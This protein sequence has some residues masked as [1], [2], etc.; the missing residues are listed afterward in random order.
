MLKINI[1]PET[2]GDTFWSNMYEAYERMSPSMREYLETLTA[3]HDANFFHKEAANL[4][5]KISTTKVRGNP[6]NVG[7][8]LQAHHPIIRTNRKL[9]Q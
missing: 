7:D 3:T 5:I 8:D 6:I 2:G 9:L 1:L 4:G